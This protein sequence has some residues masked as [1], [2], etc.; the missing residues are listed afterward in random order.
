MPSSG[1]P[2][3]GANYRMNHLAGSG[4]VFSAGTAAG[5]VAVVLTGANI[6]RARV[7]DVLSTR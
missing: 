5:Q 4:D 7:I 1:F 3:V 2:D 6:D